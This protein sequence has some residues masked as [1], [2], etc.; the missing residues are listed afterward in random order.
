MIGEG[1]GVTKESGT[2]IGP[3]MRRRGAQ[4]KIENANI[5]ELAR[6][7]VGTRGESPRNQRQKSRRR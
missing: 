2:E 3:T 5:R 6:R 4:M 7:G 1:A